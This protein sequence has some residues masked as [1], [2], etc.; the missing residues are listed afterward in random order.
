MVT[1][2]KPLPSLFRSNTCRRMSAASGGPAGPGSATQAP[3]AVAWG[4]P[5]ALPP[6]EALGRARSEEPSAPLGFLAASEAEGADALS[7]DLQNLQDS[8]SGHTLRTTEGEQGC[9]PGNRRRG[10]HRQS[11]VPRPSATTPP[12]TPPRARARTLWRA[13]ERCGR[14]AGEC[15]LPCID[16]CHY[17]AGSTAHRIAREDG[18]VLAVQYMVSGLAAA[19]VVVVHGG[20]VVVDERHGVDHL[21]AHSGWARHL[22][23][24]AEHLGSSEAQHRPHTLA[25]GHQRVPHRL[26]DQIRLCA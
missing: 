5:W 22:H 17:Y 2:P 9:A 3:G 26:D 10:G 13:S 1:S 6:G 18:H 8:L 7:H 23:G 11:G 15:A 14:G 16:R 12:P 20:Q 19:E 25:S 21:E 4:G 24:A